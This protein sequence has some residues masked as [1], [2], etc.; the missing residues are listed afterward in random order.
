MRYSKHGLQSPLVAA[1]VAVLSQTAFAGA[2]SGVEGS[3]SN[4]DTTPLTEIIVTA[5]KREEKL[6]EVADSV[7]AFS[8]DE[9]SQRGAQSFEDY[10]Q[11]APGVVF[12]KILP[13]QSSITIRG[14]GT[15]TASLDQGQGTTGIYLNGIPLTD[16]SYAVSIPDIDTFDLQRVEVLRGPQGTLFGT[17][18]LGGAVNYITNPV[19]LDAVDA[20]LESGVSGTQSSSDVGYSAKGAFNLPII[21]DVLGVR[22]TAVKRFDP[23]YVD[24]IGT[25]RTDANS[26]DVESFRI[27]ALWQVNQRVAVNFLSFYDRQKIP[28]LSV[29]IPTLGDLKSDTARPQFFDFVTQ[30][31]DLKVDADLNFADSHPR[32]GSQSEKTKI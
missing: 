5:T 23:G 16:P 30:I 2:S 28:D 31:N 15:S 25:G 3:S 18:T 21:S 20:R 10:I 24:N 1:L 14:V 32:W 11:S 7:T 17:A 8:G 22:V 19:R 27:N 4:S 13:S 12:D 9:L 6:R 26:R 29:T